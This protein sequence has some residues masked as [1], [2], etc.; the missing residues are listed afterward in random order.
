M[1]LGQNVCEDCGSVDRV[2]WTASWPAGRTL[3]DAV[4]SFLTYTTGGGRCE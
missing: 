3:A 1:G 2:V 4:D